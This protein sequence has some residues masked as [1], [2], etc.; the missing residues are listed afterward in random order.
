MA[1]LSQSCASGLAKSH[2][3]QQTSGFSG[4]GQQLAHHAAQ[5]QGFVFQVQHPSLGA[6]HGVHTQAKGTIDAL[7]H[8]LQPLGQLGCCGL[9]KAKAGAADFLL[10]TH[11]PLRQRRGRQQQRGCH[12]GHFQS[13]NSLQHQRDAHF[14]GN[15]RM[16]A[17]KQQ[18]EP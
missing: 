16:R 3:R 8:M 15:G 5:V 2:Q 11:Q 7:K 6:F 10:R 12:V 1:F 9:F 14:F 17:D 4:L 13:Q 18:F